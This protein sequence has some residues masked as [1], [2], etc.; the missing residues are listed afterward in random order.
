MSQG[1]D[2]IGRLT[3]SLFIPNDA[4][5]ERAVR[6]INPDVG[7]PVKPAEGSE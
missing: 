4:K 3:L 7:A 5:D 6:T 1:L 2:L